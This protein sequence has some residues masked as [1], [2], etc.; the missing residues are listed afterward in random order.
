LGSG[1]HGH[2]TFPPSTRHGGSLDTAGACVS[3]DLSN[4]SSLNADVCGWFSQ[5]A[6]IPGKPTLPDYMRTYNVDVNSG[7]L[8]WSATM[9]WRAPGTAPVLGSGCGL[10]GGNIVPLPNGGQSSKQ[11]LDGAHLPAMPATK[12]Q[13]GSEQ[14]VG[15]SLTANHGGGYQWRLCKVSDGVS[16]EC[17]QKTPL[18]FAGD[19]TT[20]HYKP[21]SYFDEEITIPRIEI[22]LVK[23]SDGTFPKGSQWA[24]VPVPSCRFCDQSIC[25]AGLMPN[26]TDLFKP[27]DACNGC[28]AA[29]AFHE[30]EAGGL[31]WFKQ[32]LCG[33]R[34]AGTGFGIHCPPGMSQF[35]EPAPGISGY[36][37]LF[38]NDDYDPANPYNAYGDGLEYSI[39][40]KVI[41]PQDLE[42]GDYLLSWR[43]DA[44]QSHQV[45]Q[46][47][48]DITIA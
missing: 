34:C 32:Q 28:T 18:A 3:G 4:V 23:T 10:G 14:E 6:V 48:A 42:P 17:F 16:E 26:M 5:P 21:N 27:A 20:L 24:R 35:P 44:E 38:I 7:S 37:S 9:P 36:S 2:I 22:P 13:L 30:Y 15:F 47:C 46:N 41:V 1:A 19:K 31:P 45:W 43:W 40:D 39:V 25:G 33:Q 11:G 29:K 8:D 12:W